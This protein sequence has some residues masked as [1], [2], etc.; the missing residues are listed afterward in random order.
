M[1]ND[2][3]AHLELQRRQAADNL[4]PVLLGGRDVLQRGDRIQPILRRLRDD[5]VGDAVLR[6][7]RGDPGTSPRKKPFHVTWRG[8]ARLDGVVRWECRSLN[9]SY[10]KPPVSRG[11]Q[12][13]HA[14]RQIGPTSAIVSAWSPRRGR[15]EQCVAQTSFIPVKM[16]GSSRASLAA[17]GRRLNVG[18]LR[19][20]ATK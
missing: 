18:R 3:G 20:P 10:S 19:R 5:R 7:D 14:H 16:R 6:V 13:P 11:P 17:N 8:P 15:E 1:R 2:R 9:S 4:R 12:A